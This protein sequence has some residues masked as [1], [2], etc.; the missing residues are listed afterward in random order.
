M[1]PSIP[2]IPLSCW[3]MAASLPNACMPLGLP[4]CMAISF[5]Q[6]LLLLAVEVASVHRRLKRDCG[7]TLLVS[8]MSSAP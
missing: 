7:V 3:S 8:S 6:L 5:E 4:P 1:L 2:I